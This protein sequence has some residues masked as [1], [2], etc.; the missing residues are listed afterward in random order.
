M[1]GIDCDIP[2]MAHNETNQMVK[3]SGEPQVS[4]ADTMAVPEGDQH[5]INSIGS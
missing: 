1:A 5:S 4:S 3:S 2:T